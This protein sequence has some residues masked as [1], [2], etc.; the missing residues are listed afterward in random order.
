M[1]TPFSKKNQRDLQSVSGGIDNFFIT[2]YNGLTAVKMKIKDLIAS[3]SSYI[4]SVVAPN[5][6]LPSTDLGYPVSQQT[7][8]QYALVQVFA[9]DAVSY[10]IQYNENNPPASTI[11]V[12]KEDGSTNIYYAKD[13]PNGVFMFNKNENNLNAKWQLNNG[14]GY[15]EW[16]EVNQFTD[17][18]LPVF[19]NW[20]FVNDDGIFQNYDPDTATDTGIYYLKSLIVYTY[21]DGNTDGLINVQLTVL[22]SSSSG[23]TTQ[24]AI[25]RRAGRMAN[26]YN[27][28]PAV[29]I[30][31][32]PMGST[33]E[34][35]NWS[36]ASSDVYNVVLS[37]LMDV[38]NNFYKLEDGRVRLS[39][40]ETNDVFVSFSDT[41]VR[42]GFGIDSAGDFFWYTETGKKTVPLTVYTDSTLVGD[43][44][45]SSPIGA[46]Y[47]S[48]TQGGII[49]AED[50]VK[51]TNMNP[52]TST[53]GDTVLGDGSEN[54]KVRTNVMSL[55]FLDW[56]TS[57]L[58]SGNNEPMQIRAYDIMSRILWNQKQSGVYTI[59]R[60]TYPFTSFVPEW[61]RQ[62]FNSKND[63]FSFI[64]V[65]NSDTGE[66]FFYVTSYAATNEPMSLLSG[67]S[68]RLYVPSTKKTYSRYIPASL[69][70]VPTSG[71]DRVML[72]EW[73]EDEANETYPA[74]YSPLVISA[75][76]E[77]DSF[78]DF[79]VYGIKDPQYNPLG[80]TE[81]YLTLIVNPASN[82]TTITQKIISASS[83]KSM[84]RFKRF[85]NSPW[86]EWVLTDTYQAYD[87]ATDISKIVN[88]DY[89]TE[90]GSVGI[91]DSSDPLAQGSPL[92]NLKVEQIGYRSSSSQPYNLMQ[93]RTAPLNG[94]SQIRVRINGVWGNWID[95][96]NGGGGVIAT[97]YAELQSLVSS[98]SLTV[99]QQYLFEYECVYKDR[100]LNTGTARGTR[101][102][103]IIVTAISANSFN[104][105]VVIPEQPLWDVEYSF[106]QNNPYIGW[107]RSNDFGQIT[108]LKD[109]WGNEAGFDFK[110]I[111]TT[112]YNV[113]L[114]NNYTLDRYVWLPTLNNFS[115]GTESPDITIRTT[116]NGEPYEENIK[117]GNFNTSAV[118]DLTTKKSLFLFDNGNGI[119]MSSEKHVTNCSVLPSYANVRPNSRL[120]LPAI[121]LVGSDI[122]DC[123]ITDSERML[124][125]GD[126]IKNITINDA[127]VVFIGRCEK[128]S[129]TLS[130]SGVINGFVSN[131]QGMRNSVI[132]TNNENVKSITVR[133]LDST[134]IMDQIG[135]V[136]AVTIDAEHCYFLAID[137]AT[138]NAN[139][140]AFIS[141]NDSVVGKCDDSVIY[142]LNH[143]NAKRIFCSQLG[144]LQN[145][146]SITAIES[147][148]DN[149]ISKCNDVRF[150][151]TFG[152]STISQCPLISFENVNFNGS[153]DN[154]SLN[155]QES[156][157]LDEI[158]QSRIDYT[159]HLVGNGYSIRKCNIMSGCGHIELSSDLE[160]TSIGLHN[161]CG[162]GGLAVLG[163]KN[164]VISDHCIIQS[165]QIDGNNT[166]FPIANDAT[167]YSFIYRRAGSVYE[168]E[169]GD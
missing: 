113:S 147:Y 155:L 107:A 51:L 132:G 14:V 57:N 11:T 111:K 65:V 47:A 2:A 144:Q 25:G 96:S 87:W 119:D 166:D 143:T 77:Y 148:V 86:S 32:A 83:G 17:T 141:V 105:K 98:S 68:Q 117:V 42:R 103:N 58:L 55:D 126:T 49:S 61:W 93:T 66:L 62:Y 97:T 160:D 124:I 108:Y 140:S 27:Q 12:V 59:T 133:A 127:R 158:N 46:K 48:E 138:V 60:Q 159:K 157:E 104:K 153:I 154:S 116:I 129:S 26:S 125:A 102:F 36:S 122:R 123:K 7:A 20:G 35:T 50:Y 115:L 74:S 88:Y 112:F 167:R 152:Y 13:I 78:T 139:N 100:G 31:R 164:N 114:S 149:G 94:K 84:Q 169:I 22:N 135:N 130:I 73:V 71:T 29:Y 3:F 161:Y 40:S 39:V 75:A 145:V 54:D 120:E 151:K 52:I 64:P 53:D 15:F 38:N 150:E 23:I 5:I 110:N 85:V 109:E 34:W 95:V 67:M 146:N 44:S 4:E 81:G 1:I 69:I 8:T 89:V 41:N 72:P 128:N 63:A 168:K 6:A 142:S 92:M 162:D 28:E 106:T 19:E 18:G 90:F 9:K 80:D 91:Y 76:S 30:R 101:K 136:G 99:G 21:S 43:G 37:A 163:G 82:A 134:Y 121:S 118:I 70:D 24:V 56:G 10:T 156:N 137:N 131:Q 165:I 79:G 45:A 33:N 16:I